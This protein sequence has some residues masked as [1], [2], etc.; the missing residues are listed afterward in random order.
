MSIYNIDPL[1]GFETIAKKVNQFANEV[2]KNINSS[3]FP[4]FTIEKNIFN[5]RVDIQELGDKYIL[6]VELAGVKKE[7]VKISV[8]DD[9]S[10]SIS[11]KKDNIHS[12]I[13]KNKI[14]TERLY[15]VFKRQFI[16]PENADMD[17]IKAE[18]QE[19]VLEISI[20]KKL[21]K[22]PKETIIEIK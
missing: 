11:G 22:V 16:L 14:R 12:E 9:G 17:T 5:P 8:L 10:L 19:G 3:D 1:R 6:H 15:G 20:T 2:E 4:S 18:Y 13:G 21:P 7:E